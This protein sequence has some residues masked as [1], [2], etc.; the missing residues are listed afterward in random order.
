MDSQSDHFN[1]YIRFMQLTDESKEYLK[2][3]HT[4]TQKYEADTA[5]NE[6]I[7]SMYDCKLASITVKDPKSTPDEVLSAFETL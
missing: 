2:S 1:L 4:N 6:M 5:D 3:L 7:A